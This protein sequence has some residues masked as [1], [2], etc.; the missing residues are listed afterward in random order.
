[1]PLPPTAD[2]VIPPAFTLG[3]WPDCSAEFM[4]L[5]IPPGPGPGPSPDPLVEGVSLQLD[6]VIER[7]E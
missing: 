7:H 6:I 3:P 1:M 4:N 5:A 2:P